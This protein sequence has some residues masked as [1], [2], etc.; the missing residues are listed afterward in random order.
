MYTLKLKPLTTKN[1]EISPM[2]QLCQNNSVK[3]MHMEIYRRE[4]RINKDNKNKKYKNFSQNSLTSLNNLESTI[5]SKDKLDLSNFILEPSKI[6][7]K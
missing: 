3:N 5:Y 4:N 7:L 2:N 1:S 6:D